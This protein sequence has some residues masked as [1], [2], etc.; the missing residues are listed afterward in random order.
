MRLVKPGEVM[1]SFPKVRQQVAELVTEG[2][3]LT[4]L[5]DFF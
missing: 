1:T 3:P 4:D 5:N 2:V